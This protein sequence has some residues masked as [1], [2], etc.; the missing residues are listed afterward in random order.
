MICISISSNFTVFL[1]DYLMYELHTRE[2]GQ[3]ESSD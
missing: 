3:C 2:N 1:E